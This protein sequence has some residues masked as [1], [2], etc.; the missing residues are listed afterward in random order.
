MN[1]GYAGKVALITGAGSG[2]GQTLAVAFA[3]EGAKVAIN[4]VDEAGLA[5]TALLVREQSDEAV[6]AAWDV[7]RVDDV[8]R[9]V[10]QIQQECGAI[11]V[12]VNNAAVMLNNTA[13]VEA[14][15]KSCAREIEVALFGTLNCARAVLP[16]MVARRAGKIV[17]I[18]SDAGRVG[19]ERE[20][21]YS[22]A[23][24][25]VIAFT[26]SLAREVGRHNINVNA[27]SP[28]ATDTPLR[29]QMLERIAEKIGREAM[30]EREEKI[31]RAYPLRR[32]GERED[33][34][35][36]VLFLASDLAKHITGQVLS[37]N[38]GYAMVG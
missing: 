18:V 7:S 14:D 3:K 25:G 33:V 9:A 5:A 34:A 28:A 8:Q 29:R 36:A 10:A 12:L 35:N 22:A 11:D 16:G 15:P 2:I 24:G 26:K 32:I 38:G 13:F 6:A 37:V 31:R 1:F 30:I 23:K 17:N 20:A 27:V 19:Q 4:D 21:A